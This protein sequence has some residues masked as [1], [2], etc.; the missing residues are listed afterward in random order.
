MGIEAVSSSTTRVDLTLNLEPPA[1]VRAAPT[2]SPS[3]PA[4]PPSGPAVV[5]ETPGGGA[6]RMDQLLQPQRPP[7]TQEAPGVFCGPNGLPE[8]VRLTGTELAARFGAGPVP[9][10]RT[11]SEAMQRRLDQTPNLRD[12]LLTTLGVAGIANRIP[13]AAPLLA[14]PLLAALGTEVAADALRQ[15]LIEGRDP[16]PENIRDARRIEDLQAQVAT[17]A[18]N[19]RYVTFQDRGI[20]DGLQGRPPQLREGQPYSNAYLLGYD[21]AVAA[22]WGCAPEP[23]AQPQT[24]PAPRAGTTPP[25]STTTPPTQTRS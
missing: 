12:Q 25:A 6:S 5:L 2:T 23:Q 20:Q 10:D 14:A 19:E 3:V 17:A 1:P 7:T 15:V 9:P 22:R 8:V 11:A 4:G 16:T 21:R 24:P 18:R 13:G